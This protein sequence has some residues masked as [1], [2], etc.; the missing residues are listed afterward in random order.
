[1]K[2]QDEEDHS[3]CKT[4]SSLP[5]SGYCTN[6]YEDSLSD[7][8]SNSDKN[9]EDTS[10]TNDD[11]DTDD[12]EDRRKR[13]SGDDKTDDD[14]DIEAAVFEYYN[15]D[16]EPHATVSTIKGTHKMLKNGFDREGMSNGAV[17]SSSASTDNDICAISPTNDNEGMPLSYILDNNLSSVFS[18]RKKVLFFFMLLLQVYL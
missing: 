8:L 11:V 9:E 14:T 10:D 6:E 15:K 1:M 4:E 13:F 17:A 16:S 2:L 18:N 7:S 12:V 5:P 3:D